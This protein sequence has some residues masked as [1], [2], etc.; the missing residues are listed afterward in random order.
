[1]P[2]GL[3]NGDFLI[4]QKLMRLCQAFILQVF[5]NG[6]AK[7]FFKMLFEFEAI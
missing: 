1:M 4:S 7:E 5:E 3:L 6:G 2:G